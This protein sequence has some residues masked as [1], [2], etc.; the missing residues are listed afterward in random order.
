M[1]TDGGFAL[2]PDWVF[3]IAREI[4]AFTRSLVGPKPESSRVAR[5]FASLPPPESEFERRLL[6]ALQISLTLTHARARPQTR[7]ECARQLILDEYRRSWTL[8]ALSRAVGCNRT[9]LQKEFHKLT[10]R[11]VHRFVVQ[12]RVEAA[13][14]L[15]ETT[16]LKVSSV[17]GEVGYRSHSAFARHFRTIMGVTPKSYRASR[18]GSDAVCD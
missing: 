1:D 12:R 6:H 11:T 16:S 15:L 7:A 14:E 18:N 10:G 4:D 3:H 17:S 2:R 5:L 8:T 9:T 13:A